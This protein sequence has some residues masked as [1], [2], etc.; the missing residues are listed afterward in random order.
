MNSKYILCAK[1]FIFP[2]V[3][4]LLLVACCAHTDY[5]P[6]EAKD[7]VF[8]GKGGT[9]EIVDEMEFWENG[10]PPRKFKILGIIEDQRPGG[11]IPMSSLRSDIVEKARE[12]DGD[13]VIQIGS[14]SH[15]TGFY[16]SGSASAYSYGRSTTAYGSSTTIPVRRNFAKFIVIKYLD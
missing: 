12:V 15:I 10:E 3:F 14:Q 1:M 8:E 4:L 9:K 13:A 2:A 7:N 6:F 5:K 11:L 16:N